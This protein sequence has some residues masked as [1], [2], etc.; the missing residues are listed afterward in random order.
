MILN[1]S[2]AEA[3]YSAVC[4]LSNAG[5][6]LHH[7]DF[8]SHGSENIAVVVRPS[9]GTIAVWQ[10]CRGLAHNV[11]IHADQSAFAASYSLS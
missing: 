7:M 5:G 8:P 11:E 6:T 9:T 10:E 4:A 1:K 3:V 2:Q